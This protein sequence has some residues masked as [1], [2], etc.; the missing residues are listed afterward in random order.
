MNYGCDGSIGPKR[1][2]VMNVQPIY[3]IDIR[4]RDSRQTR[5]LDTHRRRLET[6]KAL[7]GDV[8]AVG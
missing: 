8:L 2:Q 7:C 4:R 3:T 1:I 5:V 6:V